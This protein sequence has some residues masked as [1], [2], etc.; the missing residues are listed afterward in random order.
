MGHPQDAQ[1]SAFFERED[2]APIPNAQPIAVGQTCQLLDV[3]RAG[4]G[5][6]FD[7]FVDS[8]GDLP[9]QCVKFTS[10]PKRPLQRSHNPS[11]CRIFS[12]S[13]RSPGLAS[14][15]GL[16]NKLSRIVPKRLLLDRAGQQ[17]ARNRVHRDECDVLQATST[18][19]YPPARR[20]VG[21]SM[22]ICCFVSSMTVITR[23][24]QTTL[25]QPALRRALRPTPNPACGRSPDL[26]PRPLFARRFPGISAARPRL[27]PPERGASRHSE[28]SL[29]SLFRASR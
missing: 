3:S 29:S 19:V 16:F 13:G 28:Q 26:A 11:S 14:F 1:D 4:R 2:Q 12:P 15:A 10:R 24:L 27:D 23:P 8:L 7:R 18:Q 9:V 17:A 22:R 5:I 20:S 6:P 21:F 25:P